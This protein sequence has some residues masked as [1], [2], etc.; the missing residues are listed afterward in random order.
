MSGPSHAARAGVATGAA[1]REPAARRRSGPEPRAEAPAAWQQ[2]ARL[3]AQR[4]EIA[5]AFGP[6]APRAAT[7]DDQA[8]PQRAAAD[9][10]PSPDV[11]SGGAAGG[12]PAS[13][14]A[15][16]EALSG[17][18]LSDVRVHRHSGHPAQLNALAYAQGSDIHLGA[19]Q[20]QHLPHEAWHVVQQRQGRVRPTTQLAGV[21]VNDDDA[22][23]HEADVMGDR[24][25]KATAMPLGHDAALQ[26]KAAGAPAPGGIPAPS[27]ASVPLQ[28]TRAVAQL[29]RT[30]PGGNP[31]GRGGKGGYSPPSKGGRDARGGD[32]PR[33]EA[34]RRRDIG[35]HVQSAPAPTPESQLRAR[36]AH[37]ALTDTEVFRLQVLMGRR[38]MA[39]VGRLGAIG[40]VQRAA[41]LET[42]LGLTLPVRD[43][44]TL[45]SLPQAATLADL[46]RLAGLPRPARDLDTLASLPQAAALA[47]LVLVSGIVK[48]ARDIAVVAGLAQAA[49]T[50]DL[51]QLAGLPWSGEGIAAVAAIRVGA[52]NVALTLPEIVQLAATGKRSADIVQLAALTAARTA[53]QLIQIAGEVTGQQSLADRSVA[54]GDEWNLLQ[55]GWTHWPLTALFQ[56]T[57]RM[58]QPA[59]AAARAAVR[60]GEPDADALQ[61]FTV[62]KFRM[63]A[64]MDAIR[65]MVPALQ[66]GAAAL[67]AGQAR[68]AAT[69]TLINDID[70]LLVFHSQASPERTLAQNARAQAVAMRQ[71][72][73]VAVQAVQADRAAYALLTNLTVAQARAHVQTQQTRVGDLRYGFPPSHATIRFGLNALFNDPAYQGTLAFGNLNLPRWVQAHAY[74]QSLQAGDRNRLNQKL[75][76]FAPTGWGVQGHPASRAKRNGYNGANILVPVLPPPFPPVSGEIVHDWMFGDASHGHAAARMAPLLQHALN[77]T[78]LVIG[79]NFVCRHQSYPEQGRTVHTWSNHTLR[80]VIGGGGTVVTYFNAN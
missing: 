22:L 62:A 40:L 65:A 28:R 39:E 69:G 54:I 35:L 2:S 25:A 71:A 72:V 66:E 67:V 50:A 33:D 1:E 18:D 56:D 45:A 37:L 4:R 49:G 20:D 43:I 14:R 16:V 79:A 23:E 17:M 9:R 15:G 30:L 80:I 63:R 38:T 11:G 34:R 13:L 21:D 74:W 60:G 48:P 36:L 24:A 64:R 53:A 68:I 12:L 8:A 58:W 55:T 5:A 57:D 78:D 61:A 76:G 29:G 31:L 41:D 75:A 26:A 59:A 77:G 73:D 19:G 51:I 52:N 32:R 42:L 27:M 7:P 44:E 3:A 70:R 10:Q 6:A 46:V 47:D